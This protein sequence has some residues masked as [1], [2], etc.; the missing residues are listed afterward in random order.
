MREFDAC[1]Q[2]LGVDDERAPF[3]PSLARGLDYYT[4][5]V[6]E[7]AVP[8]WEGGSIAG[9]GR[10]D[11]LV[12]RF[13]DRRIPCTGLAFGLERLIGALDYL[14]AAPRRRTTVQ[15]L[16]VGMGKTPKSELLKLAQELRD[17]GISTEPYFGKK[18]GMKHQLGHADHYGIPV[19]VIVGEDELAAGTV[20]IK[21]LEAGKREREHIEDRDAY[22]QAGR[23]AQ[24]TVARG[25][26]VATVRAI[27]GAA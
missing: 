24:Q 7:V 15:A 25:E 27:L 19:A 17:A 1:L 14:G 20:S 23:V 9:G 13:L 16:V 21:D 11:D 26:M 12:A 3:R 4:G 5:P 8:G 18:K 10:Y 2:A 6:F 22:R